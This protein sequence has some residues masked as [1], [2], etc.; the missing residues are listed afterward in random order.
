MVASTKRERALRIEQA[1]ATSPTD[2]VKAENVPIGKLPADVAKRLADDLGLGQVSAELTHLLAKHGSGFD[3]AATLN[4]AAGSSLINSS[5]M[6]SKLIQIAGFIEDRASALEFTPHLTDISKTLVKVNDGLLKQRVNVAKANAGIK[7][8]QNA[9]FV[10]TQS[11]AP[12]E[13]VTV[14]STPVTTPEK[15]A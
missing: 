1:L 12:G 11:F 8:V 2:P 9:M 15:A 4:A 13:I 7:A 6:T 10:P 14:E 5:V 3:S